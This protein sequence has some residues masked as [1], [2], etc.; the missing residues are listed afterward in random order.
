MVIQI[1]ISFLK[2][3]EGYYVIVTDLTEQK[4]AEQEL[5]DL[6]KDLERS[7]EE[8]KQFAYVSSHDLQEP[9]RTIA[10]FTQL[11]ER[12]YKGKFDKDADEFMEYIVEAA[13]RMQRM[14][15]HLL[16]YS[17][18]STNNEEFEEIDTTAVLDGAL[19]NLRGAIENNKAVITHN[20]LPAVTADKSQLIKVFQ[21]LIANAIKFKKEDE[22]PKI[23]VSARKDLQKNQYIFSVQ[24]N[25]IGMDP[26]YA[27]R[28][29]TLFQRL[30]TRDEYQGTGI[31]LSVAKRIV[32]RHGC[33]IWVE[34]ELGKGSTFYF[35]LPINPKN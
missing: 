29:F 9:L 17:R 16:E 10:S 24:D 2:K 21:N 22:P 31:G 19:F 14:I 26:Q 4:K 30:H 27:E 6:L 5:Q 1:N 7:N 28:I 8:L 23:H 12:R 15:L 25:G 34:S 13:K 35:S 20:D 33:R 3:I 11:L 32:E 18:V